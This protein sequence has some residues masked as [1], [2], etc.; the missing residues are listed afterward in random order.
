MEEL[1]SVIVP[2][3]KIED[4]LDRCIS[5]IVN[6]TYKNLEIILVDD[7]SPDKCPKIC[8]D[9]LVKDSRIKVIHKKNGGLSDARNKGLKMASGEY[10]SFIDGDDWIDNNFIMTLYKV[11][12]QT[13]SDIVECGIIKT[14]GLI[15]FEDE[16]EILNIE[17]LNVIKKNNEDA[18]RE[19]IIENLFHQYVW[20]KLYKREVIGNFLFKEGK[21]HEDEFWTYRIFSNANLVT[22]V[23][24]NMYFYFQRSDSIMGSRFSKNRLDSLEAKYERQEYIEINYPN[25]SVDAKKN[26]FWTCVYLEQLVLNYSNGQD[27]KNMTTLIKKYIKSIKL[28]ILD[29]DSIKEKIW[30]IFTKFSFTLTCYIRNTFK[31]G[32]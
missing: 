26:F 30:L 7:G 6:Q 5:S 20:N 9:W 18:M 4:Y 27:K 31:I 24:K 15:D 10:I 21:Y 8:D 14:N 29:F 2:I 32:F 1:V 23:D 12:K 28:S 19:L 17:E 22:F 13:N 16:N 3:Y 25:I 11:M